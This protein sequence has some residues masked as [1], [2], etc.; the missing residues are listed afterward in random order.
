MEEI[1]VGTEFHE[2]EVA[3]FIT[4]QVNHLDNS[5]VMQLLVDTDFD[6]ETGLEVFGIQAFLFDDLA[7]E[8][9]SG[10]ASLAETDNTEGA[11]A[12]V[13]VKIVWP[14]RFELT[15]HICQFLFAIEYVVVYFTLL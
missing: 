10:L 2:H 4:V 14:D 13:C 3:G 5:G 1:F 15:G 7:S 12:D 11:I 9:F 6:L 8:V